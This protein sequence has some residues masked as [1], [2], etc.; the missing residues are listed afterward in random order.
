MEALTGGVP[1]PAAHWQALRY[2]NLYRITVCGFFLVLVWTHS[3]PPPFGAHAPAVFAAGVSVYF[4]LSLLAHVALEYRSLGHTAQV[5][6]QVLLDIAIL[7]LLLYASGG[8]ASGFGLLL[9]V[10]IALASALTGGRTALLFASLATTAVLLEEV[11]LWLE[12]DLGTASY[13][14]AGFLG[15]AFFAT[16][17]L[18]HAL[19]QRLYVSERLAE[20]RGLDLQGLDQLNREIV[21][22]MRSGVLVLDAAGEIRLANLAAQGLLGSEG[23]LVGK[24]IGEVSP[25]LASLLGS[26]DEAEGATRPLRSRSRK[27]DLLVSRAKPGLGPGTGA[28]VFIEDAAATRQ[29][30]QQLKLASLGRLTASIAHEIR[31]PLG[32]IS[33]ATQLLAESPAAS[34]QDQRLMRIVKE[35][36]E[37]MNRIIENV[38]NLGRRGQPAPESLS[39]K[40]WLEAFAAEL[41]ERHGLA[42]Q[43]IRV[44]VDPPDIRI[45]MDPSQLYQVLWNLCEN[46][47]RYSKGMPLLE[48]SCGA[49]PIS[50]A[51]YLDVRD[52]GPGIPPDLADRVF[53]PFV[54]KHSS[55]TGLGLYIASELCEA[56]QANL[57]LHSNTDAGCCFRVSFAHPGRQQWLS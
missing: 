39:I 38:L 30:A 44:T 17:L 56:N 34:P 24:P 6:G 8:V 23:T 40:E 4:I 54:S 9:I 3:V 5:T 10:S 35:Q 15:A 45:M 28:L 53:E 50:K 7:T 22:R 42:A 41:R 37:R 51:P 11:Y 2:F 57:S 55:G 21:Q 26:W 49:K 32:A 27:T 29:R 12:S 52:H 47:L 33:H 36:T 1:T 48:L 18:G 20:Q 16:A 31:N 46:A 25:D 14:Q 43:A 13:A 19:S